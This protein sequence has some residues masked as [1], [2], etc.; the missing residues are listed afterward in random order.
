[1][2]LRIPNAIEVILIKL[3][4][5]LGIMELRMSQVPID[6]FLQGIS[7]NFALGI[8]PLGILHGL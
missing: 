7:L 4:D 3:A 1:M 6:I 5:V 2:K 8:F